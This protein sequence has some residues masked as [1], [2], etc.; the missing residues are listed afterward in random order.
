MLDKQAGKNKITKI[1]WPMN[2]DIFEKIRINELKNAGN[3]ILKKLKI[4]LINRPMTITDENKKK[5][6]MTQFHDDPIFGGHVGQKKLYSKLRSQ[7]FWKNMT[8]LIKSS[9]RQKR[10]WF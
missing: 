8:L 9:L 7:Y 2:D 1:Q 10:K 5:Q 3:K 4:L 6:L